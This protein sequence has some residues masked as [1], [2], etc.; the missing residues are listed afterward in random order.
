MFREVAEDTLLSFEANLIQQRSPHWTS[1]DCN[2]NP[3]LKKAEDKEFRSLKAPFEFLQNT[4]PWPLHPEDW[5]RLF[6]WA[7]PT[8]QTQKGDTEEYGPYI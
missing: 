1:K 8:K 3:H 2:V 4:V 6:A 5:S 7:Y